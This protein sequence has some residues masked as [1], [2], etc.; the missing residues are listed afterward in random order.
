MEG[1][2][3]VPL[4]WGGQNRGGTRGSPVGLWGVVSVMPKHRFHA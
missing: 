4:T 3:D 1:V 2:Y